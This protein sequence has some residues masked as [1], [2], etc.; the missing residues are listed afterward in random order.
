MAK[1]RRAARTDDNQREIVKQLRSIPGVTVH[2][3]VDDILVGRN[4]KN[5]WIELKDPEKV[6]KKTGGLKAG[7]MKKSQIKLKAEW[8]GQYL[9]AWTLEQILQEIG[10]TK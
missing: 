8:K 1:Y 5:Y 3:G 2:T 4:G 7:T 9:V 6:L 10:V